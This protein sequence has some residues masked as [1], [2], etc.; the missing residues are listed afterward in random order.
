MNEAIK[1]CHKGFIT[2]TEYDDG[3]FIAEQSSSGENTYSR[4]HFGP[5]SHTLA[6]FFMQHNACFMVHSSIHSKRHTLLFYIDNTP[7][8]I[9]RFTRRIQDISDFSVMV[10]ADIHPI[11]AQI[12]NI[13]IGD[14]FTK[15]KNKYPITPKV[16]MIGNQ[17]LK[18]YV[19]QQ[20]G[21]NYGR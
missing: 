7:Y 8:V 17:T 21:N 13:P 2:Y 9:T 1:N 5:F 16:P 15:L 4:I 20:L 14:M 19:K 3:S 12:V 6:Y 10:K 18:Q 11:Y